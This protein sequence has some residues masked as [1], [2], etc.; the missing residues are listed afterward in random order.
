MLCL[1]TSSKGN[2]EV[3]LSHIHSIVCAYYI[4]AHGFRMPENRVGKNREIGGTLFQNSTNVK[5][6]YFLK[7]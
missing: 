1:V 3:L 2:M 5:N 6:E 4:G 7:S